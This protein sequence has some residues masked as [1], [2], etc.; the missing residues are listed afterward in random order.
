MKSIPNDFDDPR[1]ERLLQTYRESDRA[2]LE[3]SL[4][5]TAECPDPREL[6]AL[7]RGEITA[8]WRR[9][10]LASHLIHCD[11]CA[12][13]NLSAL[14]ADSVAEVDA[15]VEAD[16]PASVEPREVLRP[17]P[18]LRAA[19]DRPIAATLVATPGSGLAASGRGR[20]RR[21]VARYAAAAALLVGA[22][23][24]FATWDPAS[25]EPGLAAVRVTDPYGLETRNVHE[26]RVGESRRVAVVA[27]RGGRLALATASATGAAWRFVD[28]SERLLAVD[29]G[30]EV[31]LP[32]D[33]ALPVEAAE[34]W[35]VVRFDVDATPNTLDAELL[36][37]LLRGERFAGV[38][39][40][41]RRFLP[42]DRA[43]R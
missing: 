15:R 21:V 8:P 29:A 16:A 19:P 34:D 24:T 9:E 26:L 36:G 2:S 23:L 25:P 37:R 27:E 38:E 11:R 13:V 31:L 33:A 43:P 28:G 35:L 4:A 42:T 1:L 5:S 17:A 32:I 14:L 40:V 7:E 41:R 30:D 12:E 6:I 3:R 39:V 22:T 10:S 20:L 18:L